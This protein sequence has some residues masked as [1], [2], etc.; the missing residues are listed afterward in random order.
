[1]TCNTKKQFSQKVSTQK[2]QR[3]ED[4]KSNGFVPQERS[5]LKLG[6]VGGDGTKNRKVQF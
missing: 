3:T 6:E 4:R 2:N 5:L 1:M